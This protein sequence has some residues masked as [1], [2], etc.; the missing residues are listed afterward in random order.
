[1]LKSSLS[2]LLAL[3]RSLQLC[4]T[5]SLNVTC[6]WPYSIQFNS[7]QFNSI[8]FAKRLITDYSLK[9]LNRQYLY[10]MPSMCPMCRNWTV[11]DYTAFLLTCVIRLLFHGSASLFIVDL[12]YFR[13]GFL[14]FIFL[15]G[16]FPAVITTVLCVVKSVFWCWNIWNILACESY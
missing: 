12:F 7:I 10:D 5:R 9:G 8:V 13:F 6:D 11:L 14:P 16:I 2:Y 15:K 1:M 4:D 3:S